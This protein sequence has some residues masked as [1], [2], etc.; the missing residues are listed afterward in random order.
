MN[1][2]GMAKIQLIERQLERFPLRRRLLALGPLPRSPPLT[3]HA[4]EVPDVKR[5]GKGHAASLLDLIAWN[6]TRHVVV[7]PLS[8]V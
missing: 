7:L 3:K 8:V 4:K 5:K 1:L 2:K 6:L